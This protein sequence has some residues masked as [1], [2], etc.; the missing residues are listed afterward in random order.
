MIVKDQLENMNSWTI[1]RQYVVGSGAMLE[2][3]SMPGRNLWVMIPDNDSM[4]KAKIK[5]NEVYSGE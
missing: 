3:Y 4:D 1:I 2:T 5:I